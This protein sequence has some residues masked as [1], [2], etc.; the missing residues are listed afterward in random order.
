MIRGEETISNNLAEFRFT[1]NAGSTPLCCALDAVV[2]PPL[3]I[4][5]FDRHLACFRGPPP[6]KLR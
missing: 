1:T 3:E 4:R 2:G 5:D 6:Q